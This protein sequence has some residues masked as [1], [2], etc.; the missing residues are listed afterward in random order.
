MRRVRPL[1]SVEVGFGVAPAAAGGSSD[2][3]F[4]LKL[5][6]DAQASIKVPSTEK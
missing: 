1:A 4:G 5:F 6:I 2:P 3:S